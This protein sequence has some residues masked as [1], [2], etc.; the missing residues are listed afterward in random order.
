MFAA[1]LMNAVILFSGLVAVV[2]LIE[3]GYA[4]SAE[5]I[6]VDWLVYLVAT[7]GAGRAV[8]SHLMHSWSHRRVINLGDLGIV[9][10]DAHLMAL[11]LP[12][13]HVVA[14]HGPAAVEFLLHVAR[15]RLLVL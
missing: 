10:V 13:A 14:K 7:E 4:L 9:I 15:G 12:V 11:L 3:V 5:L 6:H 1:T 2:L 8:L